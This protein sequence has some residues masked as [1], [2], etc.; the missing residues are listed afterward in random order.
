MRWFVKLTPGV[1]RD[2]ATSGYGKPRRCSSS[3]LQIYLNKGSISAL[4]FLFALLSPCAWG[5]KLLH[6]YLSVALCAG[7]FLFLVHFR[8]VL[9]LCDVFYFGR[10]WPENGRN[11][12]SLRTHTIVFWQF[13]V[14]YVML[15][16][17]LQ[18]NGEPEREDGAVLRRPYI[19]ML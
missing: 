18:M 9:F 19:Q 13:N 3:P 7:W 6:G 4:L 8:R 11:S 2:E 10:R 17:L 5:C 1:I 14:D 16:D 15:V 12:A